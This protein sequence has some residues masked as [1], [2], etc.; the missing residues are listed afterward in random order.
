MQTLSKSPSV[1]KIWT[2]PFTHI[3]DLNQYKKMQG[4]ESPYLLIV[5][6]YDYLQ[7]SYNSIFTKNFWSHVLNQKKK[8]KPNYSIKN[9]FCVLCYFLRLLWNPG[10]NKKDEIRQS[11]RPRQYIS[12]T[13]RGYWRLRNW[14]DHNITQRNLWHRSDSTKHFQIHIYSTAKRN[15]GQQSVNCV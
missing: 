10:R 7:L 6:F 15:Y 4:P 3:T 2:K 14:Y 12:G 8:S 1:Q 5:F 11:N 9:I 13:F